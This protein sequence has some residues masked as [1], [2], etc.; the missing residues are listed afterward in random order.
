MWVVVMWNSE[1]VTVMVLETLESEFMTSFRSL[2]YTKQ[3]VRDISFLQ[4]QHLSD[5]KP[6]L[7]SVH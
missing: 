4:H 7:N 1:D 3:Y 5:H 6:S 2:D